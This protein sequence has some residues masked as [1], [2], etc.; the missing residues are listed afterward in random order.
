MED[1]PIE[2]D[3][4]QQILLYEAM[5][6]SADNFG[7]GSEEANNLN[8]VTENTRS[9]FR[10]ACSIV[11]VTVGD[12][13]KF[14]ETFKEDWKDNTDG[15]APEEVLA[16]AVRFYTD[17]LKPICITLL[18]KNGEE[19]VKKFVEKV[20]DSLDR[21]FEVADGDAEDFSGSFEKR[22]P[23]LGIS[24]DPEARQ[25]NWKYSKMDLEA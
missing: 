7:E 11:A 9:S 15:E 14:G 2:V 3:F 6:E 21:A 1:S 20:C 24:F 8:F 4:F 16:A 22:C 12:G 19:K 5:L 23:N 25:H 10:K 17:G 18:E 13:E